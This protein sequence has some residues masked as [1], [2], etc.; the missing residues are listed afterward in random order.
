MVEKYSRK[1]QERRRHNDRLTF[2]ATRLHQPKPRTT[3]HS[4]RTLLL[5]QVTQS[6]CK[7]LVGARGEIRRAL[8]Y[9]RTYREIDGGRVTNDESFAQRAGA[10]P[11]FN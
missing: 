4:P 2:V 7:K 6:H 11:R 9:V 1:E 8:L 10:L 5:Y 3:L